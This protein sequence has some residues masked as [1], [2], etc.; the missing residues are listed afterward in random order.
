MKNNHSLKKLESRHIFAL[1]LM[2][3]SI[4]FHTFESFLTGSKESVSASLLYHI[5]LN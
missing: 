2:S 5:Q 3:N 4:Y 1:H